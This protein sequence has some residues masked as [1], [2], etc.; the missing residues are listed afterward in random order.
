VRKVVKRCRASVRNCPKLSAARQRAGEPPS[1]LW[2][3]SGRTWRPRHGWT[4]RP[5]FTLDVYAQCG[6]ADNVNSRRPDELR[7]D[8]VVP[9]GPACVF[10]SSAQKERDD[11]HARQRRKVC[12]VAVVPHALAKCEGRTG[13]ENPAHNRMDADIHVTAAP[14]SGLPYINISA[15]RAEETRSMLT[16]TGNPA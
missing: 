2:R 13:H 14:L 1:V 4:R 11:K 8:A 7:C 15:P 3:D 5:M 6:P 12:D 10:Q 9:S 16:L